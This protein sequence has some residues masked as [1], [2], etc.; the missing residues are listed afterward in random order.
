MLQVSDGAATQCVCH[1]A[2]NRAKYQ[3]EAAGNVPSNA[4]KKWIEKHEAQA[5]GVEYKREKPER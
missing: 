3:Q 2:K 4:K 1:K 5:E